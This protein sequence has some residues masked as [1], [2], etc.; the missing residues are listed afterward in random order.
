M[1]LLLTSNGFVT[2]EV[3]SKCEELAGKPKSEL[4]VAVI[5]EA[6]AVEH[7]DHRWLIDDMVRLKDNV[8]GRIEIVDLLANDNEVVSARIALAD[9]I[10][11]TGGNSDYLKRVFN[12]TGFSNILPE[13]LKTKVYVGISAGS[14]VM[15]RRISAE[16]YKVMYGIAD[17]F[18]VPEYLNL[19]DF[20]IMPHLNSGHFPHREEKLMEAVKFHKGLIYG[21]QDDSAIVVDRDKVY[22]IGSSPLKLKRGVEV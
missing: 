9:I 12:K 6:Y 4:N 11:V 1:K 13:L 22:S 3:I 8:G 10:F 7:D 17:E 2:P 21:L 15:G 20:S 19:V 14:M 18:S 16:A 5:N